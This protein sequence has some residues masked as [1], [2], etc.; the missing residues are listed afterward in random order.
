MARLIIAK[1]FKFKPLF[2]FPINATTT[3]RSVNVEMVVE[4]L[5]SDTINLIFRFEEPLIPSPK[6]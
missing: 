6:S 4:T 1:N 2:R 5:N 3:I